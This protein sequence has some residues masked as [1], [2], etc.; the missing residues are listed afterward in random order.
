M[1]EEFLHHFGIDAYR[2]RCSCSKNKAE[3]TCL[4]ICWL[5]RFASSSQPLFLFAIIVIVC[6]G[7]VQLF[8]I[9]ILYLVVDHCKSFLNRIKVW[10][11]ED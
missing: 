11:I 1:V 8:F 6:I 9:R 4:L 7:L 10:L 2:I 3:V 5:V